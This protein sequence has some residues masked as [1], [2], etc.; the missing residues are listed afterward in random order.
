MRRCPSFYSWR[1]SWRLMRR[2]EV[3]AA[4]ARRSMAAAAALTA[5]VAASVACTAAL[6]AAETS[7]ETGEAHTAGTSAAGSIAVQQRMGQMSVA[8][9]AESKATRNR[10]ATSILQKNR[11]S[12]APPA[13]TPAARRHI[14]P[15]GV[16]VAR[17]E[18]SQNW[19]GQVL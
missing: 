19:Q 1:N 2:P 8:G 7:A 12:K 17:D 3:R 9:T 10:S 4:A 14:R 15:W 5:A 18:T 16:G 13:V 6:T 11:Q